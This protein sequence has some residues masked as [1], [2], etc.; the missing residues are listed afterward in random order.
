LLAEKIASAL[1]RTAPLALLLVVAVVHA[2]PALLNAPELHPD[3]QWL[4]LQAPP[5]VCV[6]R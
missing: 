6:R 3:A 4:D 1:Q 5:A 2:L